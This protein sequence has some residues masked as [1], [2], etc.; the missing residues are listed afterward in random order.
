MTLQQ[1]IEKLKYYGDCDEGTELFEK[2]CGYCYA[3][4][5]L[6]FNDEADLICTWAEDMAEDSEQYKDECDGQF[7]KGQWGY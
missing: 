4:Y 5:G 7:I 6:G 3:L 2:T 1:R